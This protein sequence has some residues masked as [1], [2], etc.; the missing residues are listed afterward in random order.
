MEIRQL[1]KWKFVMEGKEQDVTVPHTWNVDE[2][3]EAYR[4]EAEYK[5]SFYLESHQVG[6]RVVLVFKAVYHTAKVYIN[7]VLVKE[8]KGSGFTPFEIDITDAIEAE[9]RN[10]IRVV[11]HNRYV[12]E[13]LPHIKDFDWADDG[14]IIRGVEL[15]FSEKD[16][17]DSVRIKALLEQ[18]NNIQTGKLM[19][20]WNDFQPSASVPVTLTVTHYQTGHIIM[21]QQIDK[22][23][24]YQEIPVED[25]KAWSPHS[26]HLYLVRIAQGESRT[27]SRI[28]FRNVVVRDGRVFLN[29]KKIYL[30]GCEWMPGSHPDYGMAEPLEQSIHC[31][32]QLKESGCNF[33]RFHWQ[34]DNALFDWCD[35]N[36]LMVQEEIPYWGAPKKPGELQ[37]QLAQQQANVMIQE[38]GHHPS[39]VC[40][41]VGNE[42]DGAA[43]ETITYVDKMVA[44]FKERD[45][46]RLANYV[47]NTLGLEENTEKDDA[48]LHGDIAMWNEYLGLWQPCEDIE[49]C[50]RT[51]SQKCGK[52]PLVISEFG[53]CEPSFTGGDNRR[54]EILESRI[55]IY[56][57]NL[58]IAGYIW[59]SLNDYR[60]CVG[61]EG[62]GRLM[63]RVHGSTDLYG[64]EKPSY[65]TLCQVNSKEYI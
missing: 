54:K 23:G 4:G 38:H 56:Q 27:Q 48:A 9:K 21:N 50:I 33:T 39:I 7:E 49:A 59:F 65:Q 52:K 19:I 62:E 24:A 3:T 55:A 51:T 45:K 2:C 15:R 57:T 37:L 18:K 44:Y 12:E 8:H 20:E 13:M 46:T 1:V 28:G 60:T 11:V 22:T 30:K 58:Q 35:E 6:K 42:L 53:L 29:G 26:P 16:G 31:L 10:T 5:T 25:I 34:Q 41:G 47:S 36:G 63:R 14:G 43:M 64:N 40:W 17:L 61:E 32:R